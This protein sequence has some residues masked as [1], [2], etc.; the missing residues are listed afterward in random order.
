MRCNSTW[1]H[2]SWQQKN[3]QIE[4]RNCGTQRN[5]NASP[6]VKL[7]R[8]KKGDKQPEV[9]ISYEKNSI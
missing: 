5:S 9:T 8:R 2:H 6:K 4:C 1:K 3:D 7:W